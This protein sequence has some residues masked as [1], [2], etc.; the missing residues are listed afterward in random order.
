[1]D[2]LA[3]LAVGVSTRP[4]ISLTTVASAKVFRYMFEVSVKSLVEGFR[5]SLV[6]IACFILCEFKVISENFF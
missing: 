6:R 2:L 4:E 5:S 3:D 1:M